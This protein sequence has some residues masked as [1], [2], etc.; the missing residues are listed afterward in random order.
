M[1][2]LADIYSF[3]GNDQMVEKYKK[4]IDIVTENAEADRELLRD[5]AQLD[6]G[7]TKP[8]KMS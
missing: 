2:E 3:L 8:V 5:Q 6:A 4:K 1:K 7:I